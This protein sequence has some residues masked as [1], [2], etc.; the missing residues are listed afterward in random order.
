[1]C[2]VGNLDKSGLDLDEEVQHVKILPA[3]SHG[4]LLMHGIILVPT[5]KVVRCWN[6]AG[7]ALKGTRVSSQTVRCT[8]LSDPALNF[9]YRINQPSQSIQ[10]PQTK[11]A[12]TK[13]T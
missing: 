13:V 10:N 8:S 2:G 12:T 7:P 5:P 1:M 9:S 3:H 4:E 11:L 6:V